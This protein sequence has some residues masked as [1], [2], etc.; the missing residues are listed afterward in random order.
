MTQRAEVIVIGG[1]IIGTSITYYLA[2][3][4]KNVLL[5][6]RDDLAAG[7]AGATDGYIIL[8]SKKPGIHLKMALKSAE[9]YETLTE[10]LGVDIGYRRC[11][12]YYVIES[13]EHWD[14]VK[15]VSDQQRE[16]GLDVRMLDIK[17]VRKLEPQLSEELLGASYS[18][19]DAVVNPMK[20]TFA[21]AKAAKRLG[22][23]VMTETEVQAINYQN[24]KISGVVTNKGEIKANT[25]VNATGSWGAITAKM[26]GLDLPIKPRRGQVMVT[27]PVGPFVKGIMLCGRYFAIKHRP[28]LLKDL[29]DRILRLGLGFGVE[30]TEDGNLLI[31]NT[32]E[33]VDFDRKNTLEGIEGV[34]QNAVKYLP[35][36][37]DIHIIRTFSGLRPY[38][39]D[40]FPILGPV[41]GLEGFIMAAGHEGDGVALSPI[42]G[43]IIAESIFKREIS[44]PLEPFSYKRFAS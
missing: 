33:W 5:L 43:K 27:E 18:P 9:I 32:R 3:G 8:Q 2:K 10:E 38:T 41:D 42:T 39:P 7:S 37:K 28:D 31:N 34:L 11:G 22:A 26:V 40:G 21:F 6:E 1:G 24:G 36:L 17:E 25:V 29:D 16:N 35:R 19:M 14:I 23:T 44:F 4:G 30:Q 15:Q 13:Q 12:G 20:I